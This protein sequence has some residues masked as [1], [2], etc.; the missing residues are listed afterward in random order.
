M[1]MN[2]QKPLE[3]MKAVKCLKCGKYCHSSNFHPLHYCEILKEKTT[4]NSLL[5]SVFFFIS[6]FSKFF[7]GVFF[8]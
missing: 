8:F 7:N 6:V 4:E 5:P 3:L 2:L 1:T